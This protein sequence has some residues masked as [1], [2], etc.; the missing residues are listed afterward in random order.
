MITI[1]VIEKSCIEVNSSISDFELEMF[2]LA[3]ELMIKQIREASPDNED[4]DCIKTQWIDR[5]Q[6]A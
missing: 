4:I 5:I 1:K 3:L 2:G 6:G